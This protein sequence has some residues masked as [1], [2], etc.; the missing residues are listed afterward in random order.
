[1]HAPG[2]VAA[3]ATSAGGPAVLGG[4]PAGHPIYQQ[5]AADPA[6]ANQ[7]FAN[8]A[9]GVPGPGGVPVGLEHFVPSAADGRPQ[10]GRQSRLGK[11]QAELLLAY[12]P[13]AHP[14]VLFQNR[15]TTQRKPRATTRWGAEEMPEQPEGARGLQLL[16]GN[17][18]VEQDDIAAYD[19]QLRR[20]LMYIIHDR[21]ERYDDIQKDEGVRMLNEVDDRVDGAK[22]ELRQDIQKVIDVDLANL[23]AQ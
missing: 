2:T 9:L 5:M 10:L 21:L 18:L 7:V 1:M 8:P 4:Y 15:K 12:P 14:Q 20:D 22:D 6:F 16:D 23:A 19:E 13:A 11:L 17:E 3:M